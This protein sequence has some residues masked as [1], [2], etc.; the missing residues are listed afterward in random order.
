MALG[1][2]SSWVLGLFTGGSKYPIFKDFGPKYHKGY[3]LWNHSPSTLD[4]WTLWVK[5]TTTTLRLKIGAKAL[6]TMI[7]EPKNLKM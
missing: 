1:T 7:F 4:T 2:L 3:G 5:E 6:Y